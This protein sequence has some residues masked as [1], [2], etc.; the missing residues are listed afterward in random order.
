[1]TGKGDGVTDK[2]AFSIKYPCISLMK[3]SYEMTVTV[4]HSVTRLRRGFL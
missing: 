4:R 2:T 3:G 1:M